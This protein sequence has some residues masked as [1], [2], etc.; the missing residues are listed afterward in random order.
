MPWKL[1]ITLFIVAVSSCARLERDTPLAVARC[2]LE[3]GKTCQARLM[4]LAESGVPYAKTCRVSEKDFCA[5]C[6]ASGDPIFY[7]R[8]SRTRK[9]DCDD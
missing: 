4:T 1:L 2:G 6:E 7:P 9:S 8:G 3:V 5:W